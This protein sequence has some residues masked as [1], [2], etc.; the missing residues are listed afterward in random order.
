LLNTVL[1]EIGKAQMN[2]FFYGLNSGGFSYN[3][4]FYLSFMASIVADLVTTTSFISLTS[5][6][7]R[8]QAELMVPFTHSILSE[9][10]V[11]KDWPRI[12]NLRNPIHPK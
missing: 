9:I 6:P 11:I 10:F 4:K 5:L 12:R 1:T 8:A 3:D 2:N 7:T